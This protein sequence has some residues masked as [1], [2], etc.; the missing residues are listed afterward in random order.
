MCSPIFIALFSHINLTIHSV[1]TKVTYSLTSG[2]SC[3]FGS[4]FS[5]PLLNH[6]W[7]LPALLE[8]METSCFTSTG[9]AKNSLEMS[10][11]CWMSF[12]GMPSSPFSMKTK[13]YPE[14]ASRSCE[15][16]FPLLEL[17]SMRGMSACGFDGAIAMGFLMA[18]SRYGFGDIFSP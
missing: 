10:N 11:M 4:N 8:A 12:G 6:P 3:T 13:P 5:T 14:A 18:T 7:F 16:A 15:A 2:L 1:R 17:M 9:A